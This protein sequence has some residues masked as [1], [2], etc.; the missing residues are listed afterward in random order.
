MKVIIRNENNN[1]MLIMMII[2]MEGDDKVRNARKGSE[3]QV[4]RVA[5]CD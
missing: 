2:K 3:R 4:L 5:G 1:K